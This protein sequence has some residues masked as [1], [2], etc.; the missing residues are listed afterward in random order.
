MALIKCPECGKEIS[1]NA[2][3]CP[4]CGNPV[5]KKIA[6]MQNH[7]GYKS[8]GLSVRIMIVQEG[9]LGELTAA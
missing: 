2:V 7:G 5:P 6:S 1:S 9:T 8:L 4:N 3:A